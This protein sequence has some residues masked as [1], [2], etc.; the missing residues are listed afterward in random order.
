M[1]VHLFLQKLVEYCK[2]CLDL[3]DSVSYFVK[4][5]CTRF[6][7]LKKEEGK[8]RRWKN[9][10]LETSVHL[11]LAFLYFKCTQSQLNTCS[12]P[13]LFIY[14]ICMA[15]QVESNFSQ[16]NPLNWYH[17]IQLALATLLLNFTSSHALIIYL[18]D[19][20]FTDSLSFLDLCLFS[21]LHT[22]QSRQ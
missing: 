13:A 9:E 22:I 12:S 1:N 14:F 8:G 15:A 7:E 10:D 16:L 6:L 2:T 21:N 18:L 4:L 5:K 19:Q 3:P 20:P 17:L 11:T